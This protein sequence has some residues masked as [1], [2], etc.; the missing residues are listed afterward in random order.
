LLRNNNNT[1]HLP[2]P[3]TVLTATY[4]HTW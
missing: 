3:G 4:T 1:S 2:A